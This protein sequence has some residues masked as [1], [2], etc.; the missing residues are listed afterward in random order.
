MHLPFV[1][2]DN[3]DAFAPI[4]G[5]GIMD[6]LRILMESSEMTLN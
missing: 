4:V 5:G 3:M 6:I 1:Q 2:E